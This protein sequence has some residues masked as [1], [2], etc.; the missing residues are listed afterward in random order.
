MRLTL[1]VSDYD[2]VRDLTAGRIAVEGVELTCLQM[3][4]EEIFF[5]FT[6]FR[7]W[8]VSELSLAKYVTMVAA[9]E[10][11]AA[12]PVFPSRV[13]RHSAI[14]V[15]GG[16]HVR[17]PADLAGARIGVPEWFQT[18]GVWARG[19]L[20]HEFGLRLTD[21]R[22]VQAGLRQPGRQEQFTPPAGMTVVVESGRSLIDMLLAGDLDAI[23]TARP[24]EGAEHAIVPLFPDA[25]ERERE[26]HRRTGV[27][28]IMHVIAL[29]GDVLDA[30]PWV[31][32]NLYQAFVE[33]R[34]RS[35][36]RVADLN[37][38]RFPVPWLQ[39]YARAAAADFGG[40]PFP[41]GVEANRPTLEAFLG[42]AHEQGLTPRL[43]RVEELFPAQVRRQYRI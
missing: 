6:A 43:L 7:E 38:S 5:R 19:V 42:Y 41:Y 30:H 11:V 24:P 39:T 17:E 25:A 13:F 23:V 14:Y 9:R 4:V 37:V 29:R 16:G 12:I 26:W 8:H 21:V 10:P 1:A 33:A 15:R 31:A 32:A 35:L 27:Q 28:P 34:D 22:W 40:D 2:H 18:A 3:P 20:A 36:A